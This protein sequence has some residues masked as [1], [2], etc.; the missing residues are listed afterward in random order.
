MVFLIESLQWTVMCT[1]EEESHVGTGGRRRTIACLLFAVHRMDK[2]CRKDAT[3][4]EKEIYAA[5]RAATRSTSAG[6][7][8]MVLM[9][10]RTVKE[11]SR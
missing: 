1:G 8:L 11:V 7:S 4:G 2:D 6:T 5:T 10:V 9:V 3:D